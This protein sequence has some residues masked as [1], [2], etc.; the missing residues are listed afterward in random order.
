MKHRFQIVRLV[1]LGSIVLALV[2]GA[3]PPAGLRQ[4]AAAD[5]LADPPPPL[6]SSAVQWAQSEGAEGR[7]ILLS[8][9]EGP[10]ASHTIYLPLVLRNTQSQTASAS[11]RSLVAGSQATLG[12]TTYHHAGSQSATLAASTARAPSIL[13]GYT[14]FRREVGETEWRA[15]G[16]TRPAADADEMVSILGRELAEQLAWDLAGEGARRPLTMEE[17][18]EVLMSGEP[19]VRPFAEQYYQVGIVLGLAYEDKPAPPDVDLEYY[20]AKGTGSDPLY[21]PIRIRGGATPAEPTGLSEV[22]PGP[23]QLGQPGSARPEDAEERYH[24]DDT[25]QYRSWDGKVYLIWDVPEG[26]PRF[27]GEVLDDYRGTNI[28]GYHVYRKPPLLGRWTLVNP[29]KDNCVVPGSQYCIMQI[30]PSAVDPRPSSAIEEPY[31]FKENLKEKFA[32]LSSAYA[33]WSYRV[34]AVDLLGNE[35]CSDPA[36]AYGRDLYSP[37]MVK[38][39][40]VYEPDG[41]P[42]ELSWVYSDTNEISLPLRMYVTRSPTMSLPLEEW[43]PVTPTG[44][45][46]PF[47]QIPVTST[48]ALSITDS[49]P[50]GIPHWYRVQVRDDAGNWSPF[51][52]PVMGALYPRTPPPF[53]P[54]P[55]DDQDCAANRMPLRLTGLDPRVSIVA[56]Y[57][58]FA[59]DGPWQ[60]IDKVVV[61]NGNVEI[62]DDYLPPYPRDMYYRLEAWDGH[63]NVSESQDYCTHPNPGTVPPPPTDVTVAAGC[64]GDVC[65]ASITWTDNSTVTKLLVMQGG[66]QGPET[67]TWETRD[68]SFGLDFA[69]GTLISVTLMSQNENGT[70]DGTTV[71]IQENNNF[72][73]TNR[74]MKD[75]GPIFGIEWVTE[76]VPSPVARIDLTGWCDPEA[77]D[78]RPLVSI[79]RRIRD[80]KW[81]QV[82]TVQRV[83]QAPLNIH[84]P[85]IISDTSTLM[86][87]QSYEYVVL[88]HSPTSYEVLGFWQPKVLDP[89]ERPPEP[90]EFKPRLD[91]SPEWPANCEGQSHT[92]GDL[93]L[94]AVINL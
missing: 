92:P 37:S 22:W 10:R 4:V 75:L 32:N 34:C 9:R 70:G 72:L 57:R 15:L 58:A 11:D 50:E 30:R 68:D 63:G 61:T 56:V 2:L 12:S 13:I 1:L 8:W 71:W 48:L 76:T 6:D 88:A 77:C 55:Y 33:G 54:I 42:I 7:I 78:P 80:G 82:S 21:A 65:D 51:S 40:E 24:W 84:A 19:H 94:P 69:S 26:E 16:E 89:L 18:Y 31:F 85:W 90:A 91:P 5:L 41:G 59:P 73:N 14:V 79:F 3:I 74:E 86:P 81:L 64:D 93:G 83:H 47:I 43:E 38:N 27:D 49:P 46:D 23:E 44:S 35:T 25:Q 87:Y 67:T 39:V 45:L 28:A 29:I 36:M 17:L 53:P 52:A 66:I 62:S 20:V 60:L